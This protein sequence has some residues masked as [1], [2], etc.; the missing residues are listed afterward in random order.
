MTILE[1]YTHP[2]NSKPQF[3]NNLA[4]TI[5]KYVASKAK[6]RK[7]MANGE[8]LVNGE[9]VAYDVRIFSGDIV[10]R[11]EAAGTSKAKT[12]RKVYQEKIEV[13]YE[14]EHMAILNKPGGLPVNG[15]LFKTLE[16]TLPFN[17]KPSIEQDALDVMRPL[18]RLDG[19]TCGLV[20]IAKTERAQVVMGQ[21]FEQ[22]T[23]RKRYKAV[24][25]GKLKPQKGTID[26][27]LE[28]K[29]CLTEYEVESISNSAKYDGLTLVNLYPVTGR[30]HQ[31]RIHM[32]Q[33]GHPVI[34]DKFYSEGFD[35]VNGKG[36]MLCSD[37]VWFN[38]PITQKPIE[39]AI[40]MPNKF[41]KYMEREDYYASKKTN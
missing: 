24:V 29:P 22:K 14:D 36:L 27:P 9:K 5:F 30:T 21:Q 4:P 23:I 39:V 41:R 17:L 10:T 6:A 19:P 25:I 32:S 18:H 33:L 35:V 31:L 15:N 1:T 3:L 8:L 40:E 12:N 16:N 28:G 7:M 20:L 34:G 26:T 2:K 37:K 13:V 11:L 38:H